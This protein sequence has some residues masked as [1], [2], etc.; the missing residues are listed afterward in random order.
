MGL[1]LEEKVEKNRK[2]IEIAKECGL[3]KDGYDK[4][5]IT[6]SDDYVIIH[7]IDELDKAT[8]DEDT[9]RNE[10]IPAFKR[11]FDNGVRTTGVGRFYNIISLYE[12][13]LNEFGYKMNRAAVKEVHWLFSKDIKLENGNIGELGEYFE[14]DYVLDIL[15]ALINLGVKYTDITTQQFDILRYLYENN[16]K[17]D[18]N[19]GLFFVDSPASYLFNT[20]SLRQ[21]IDAP[22][23]IFAKKKLSY[24][25]REDFG[26]M[27]GYYP[28]TAFE[29]DTLSKMRSVGFDYEYGHNFQ[30]VEILNEKIANIKKKMVRRI[31]S[32]YDESSKGK[33][34]RVTYYEYSNGEEVEKTLKGTLVNFSDDEIIVSD[35]DGTEITLK[36]SDS[37]HI[38]KILRSNRTED[39]IDKLKE[40]VVKLEAM[41]QKKEKLCKKTE[42]GEYIKDLRYM[43]YQRTLRLL[44]NKKNEIIS[45]EESFIRS[46]DIKLYSSTDLGKWRRII[47]L[48]KTLEEV[49]KRNVFDE[50]FDKFDT[51]EGLVFLKTSVNLFLKI[52]NPKQ[53]PIDNLFAA[54][55]EYFSY[56]SAET[57]EQYQDIL[58]Y[59]WA[60][61]EILNEK[62]FDWLKDCNYGADLNHVLLNKTQESITRVCDYVFANRI[63]K[64]LPP[65]PEGFVQN[66]VEAVTL[67]QLKTGIESRGRVIFGMDSQK[68]YLRVFNKVLRLIPNELVS[69]LDEEIVTRLI[70][71]LLEG[72]SKEEWR[73]IWEDKVDDEL[74][75]VLVERV[76]A[77]LSGYKKEGNGRS[78]R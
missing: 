37:L 35:K 32:K 47:K 5:D 52:V 40:E 77:M 57:K 33:L 43:D 75:R 12:I 50:Y 23:V 4:K 70:G 46:F 13:K 45:L 7:W 78:A 54:C 74:I 66:E 34:V 22:E 28:Y 16:E 76:I 55:F 67:E 42:Y 19:T 72:L 29:A 18:L 26:E 10:I 20:E 68:K 15:V 17:I 30:H 59:T 6:A 48:N 44:N 21:F 73:Q 14:V 58:G 25:K 56:P 38:S 64:D 11:W 71:E 41:V 65:I 24:E 27:Y 31:L 63:K 60:A 8:L 51:L 49:K 39:K 53:F 69:G 2:W 62:K 36:N 9:F 61:Y 1:T 3:F